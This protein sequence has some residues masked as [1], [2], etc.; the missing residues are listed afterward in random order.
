MYACIPDC[1]RG[2][3]NGDV[4]AILTAP[5]VA[6]KRPA[7][8][9]RPSAAI[10]EVPLHVHTG[11]WPW[12]MCAMAADGEEPERFIEIDEIPHMT[13]GERRLAREVELKHA[14][15][16]CV[17]AGLAIAGGCCL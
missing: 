15:L 5:F 3:Q 9:A 7:A 16:R 13:K 1:F 4:V 11:V 10:G 12:S 14:R 17:R 8:D 6:P 2:D